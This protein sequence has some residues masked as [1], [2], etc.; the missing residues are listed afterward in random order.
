[1]NNRTIYIISALV[2]LL[3]AWFSEGY[4]HPDEH[5]Q[6]LEFA[7][8]KLGQNDTAHLPW[9]YGAEM[10]PA[11]QPMI[12][13]GV[14]K[15][16]SFMGINDPFFITFF[17]RLLTA[18][19]SFLSIYMLFR[20]YSVSLVDKKLVT[21]FLLISFLLWFSLYNSVRFASDTLSGRVFIIGFAWHLLRKEEDITKY[22]ITGLLLGLSFI[23]RYQMVFMIAGFVAWLLFI[24]KASIRNLV[25]LSLGFLLIF[26]VGILADRW[27]YG[28]WTLTAWNYFQ[29]NILFDKISGFGVHPWWYYFEQTFIIALP[30]FSL[31][32]IFAVV[33]YFIYKPKEIITWTLAPFLL[34]HFIIGH[35]ELRFLYPMIGFLPVMIISVWDHLLQKRVEKLAQN[36]FVK[37]FIKAFWITNFLLLPVIIFRPVD[38]RMPIYKKLFHAKSGPVLVY[39]KEQDPYQCCLDMYYYRRPQLFTRQID[40]ISQIN[41][42][43]DTITYFVTVKPVEFRGTS[44]KPVLIYSALPEWMKRYDFNGWVERTKFWRVYKLER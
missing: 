7:A 28:D 37:I 25:M 11:I 4:N 42:G 29:Q 39:Y 35:K 26:G 17:L 22:F 13:Y 36:I 32:Y 10:R 41:P 21:A 14:H 19:V 5:F 18:A 3:T 27:L 1:M 34:V 24:K 9:E 30:P 16:F 12:A 40:S 23:L 43:P 31:V 8:M 20:L 44:Y 15:T 2:F 33:L 6:I 38:D